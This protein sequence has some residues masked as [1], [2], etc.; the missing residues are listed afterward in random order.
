MPQN[1]CGGISSSWL[2]FLLSDILPCNERSCHG[3]RC[4][5]EWVQLS[6]FLRLQRRP[7]F[8]SQCAASVW[9]ARIQDCRSLGFRLLG[10]VCSSRKRR[11]LYLEAFSNQLKTSQ[12]CIPE[13]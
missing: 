9:M 2:S 10:W 12:F 3:S 4:L 5:K 1:D 13:S 7:P 8:R 6:P 11:F